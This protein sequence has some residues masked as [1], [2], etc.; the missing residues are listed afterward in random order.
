MHIE[1]SIITSLQLI[2]KNSTYYIDNEITQA[3]LKLLIN[4]CPGQCGGHGQCEISQLTGFLFILF[5][6]FY[7]SK[8]SIREIEVSLKTTS[9]KEL[10]NKFKKNEFKVE[11]SLKIKI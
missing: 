3:G 4:L 11:R 7:K 9:T 1:L 8:N 6:F 10:N 5:Y 2:L